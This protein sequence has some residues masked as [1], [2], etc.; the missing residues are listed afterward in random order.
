MI[1]GGRVNITSPWTAILPK[2]LLTLPL[3]LDLL[4]VK[5]TELLFSTVEYISSL[6]I[7]K[8]DGQCFTIEYHNEKREVPSRLPS[9]LRLVLSSHH[10]RE[11]MPIVLRS[12]G[13]Q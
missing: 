11:P 5:A 9:A 7:Y 1:G 4:D 8:S 12:A 10:L 2:M 13:L 6:W 3:V